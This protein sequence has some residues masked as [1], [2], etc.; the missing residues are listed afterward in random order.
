MTTEDRVTR[1]ETIIETQLSK[2]INGVESISPLKLEADEMKVFRKEFDT[3]VRAIVAERLNTV[4]FEADVKET[5][6][7][8]VMA[9]F[10]RP[11]I[12]NDFEF[13]VQAIIRKEMKDVLL[14]MYIRLTLVVGSIATSLAVIVMKGLI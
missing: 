5:I 9:I 8:E 12:R 7:N 3:K 4:Q 13:K 6:N 2:I 14:G 10:N 11:E 1:L